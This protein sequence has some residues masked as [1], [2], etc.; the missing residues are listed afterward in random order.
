MAG[1]PNGRPDFDGRG[2]ML[3]LLRRGADNLW[4]IAREMW[5]AA[6][7]PDSSHR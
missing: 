4:R 1:F 2:R 5:I 6:E 3:L 7:A